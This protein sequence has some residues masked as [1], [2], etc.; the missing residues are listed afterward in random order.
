VSSHGAAWAKK[1][2]VATAVHVIG[3]AKRATMAGAEASRTVP[4]A[5][6]T[7]IPVVR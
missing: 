1:D 4:N 6:P 3:S 2:S 7:R 5:T